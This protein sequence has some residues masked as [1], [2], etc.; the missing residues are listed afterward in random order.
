MLKVKNGKLVGSNISFAMPEDFNL[1][2]KPTAV[3]YHLLEFESGKG[4]IKGG[5]IVID[6]E[7]A[8]SEMTAKEAMEEFIEDCDLSIEGEFAPITRG[9]GTAISAHYKGAEH[10]DYYEERY[11]F[12][13]NKIHQNQVTV[14]I[15]LMS[16]RHQ[17][18]G[19][20]IY[21]ALKL[22]NVKAFLDSIE[23]Y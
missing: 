15:F 9:R 4:I 23:Y 6:I 8:E 13:P 18:L 3:G 14:S 2:L 20:T 16:N 22:P 5:R 1:L 21:D 10:T 17:K 19:Q 12:K 11:D 7:L